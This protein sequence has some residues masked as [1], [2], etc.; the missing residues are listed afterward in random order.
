MCGGAHRPTHMHTHSHACACLR[1]PISTYLVAHT[2][3]G[4]SVWQRP[5][6]TARG[7]S[8]AAQSAGA[9]SA[10]RA[11]VCAC[12]CACAHW[13]LNLQ[14]HKRRVCMCVCVSARTLAAL[15]TEGSP[16]LTRGTRYRH[17]PQNLS[18]IATMATAEACRWQVDVWCSGVSHH[19]KA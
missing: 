15:L 11:C 17:V 6:R 14:V 8:R 7:A 5:G 13:Q 9:Q 12:V 2:A 10:V 3:A 1:P 16:P 19:C 18:S 4:L